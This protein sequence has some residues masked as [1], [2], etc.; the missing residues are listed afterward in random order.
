MEGINCGTTCSANFASGTVVTLTET[1]GTGHTFGGWSG[2]CTGTASTCSV[3]VS[4]AKAVTA[5]LN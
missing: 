5:K 4:A 1:P 2:A 3:T